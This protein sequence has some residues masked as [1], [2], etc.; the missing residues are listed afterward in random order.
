MTTKSK[1]IFLI[2]FCLIGITCSHV[3]IKSHVT[4]VSA[5]VKADKTVFLQTNSTGAELQSL[6][7]L[8]KSNEY[9]LT[10]QVPSGQY[11]LNKELKIYSNTTILADS[12][13]M[14]IKNHERGS[15]ITND[16]TNDK[17]GY[18][19]AFNITI[20]GGIWDS[21]KTSKGTESFRFIHAT[22]ITIQKA[23][24]CNV[25]EGSKLILFAG[26]KDSKIDGCKLYGYSGKWPK[27]AIQLD[28]VH[29]N[30]LVPSMQ[31]LYLHYDDLACNGILITNNEI[32]NY[33]RAIGSHSSVKGVFHKNITISEN[34]F[35]DLDEA[36]IKAFNYVNLLI[37]NNTITNASLGVLAYTS[38]GD[39]QSQY[40]EP[41]PGT[42]QESLPSTYNIT[43]EGNTIK[44]IHQYKS[45][46]TLIWGDGIRIMGSK[47]RPLNGVFIKKNKISNTKRMGIYT[48]YAPKGYIG[49]NTIT[50]T[51][52]HGIYVD[53]SGGSK[54]EYN[55]LTFPGKVG[56]STGGIGF[57]AS[58]KSKAYKNTVKDAAKNGIFLYNASTN[59]FISA[60]TIFR[61][62][63]NGISV[64]MSS[65]NAMI[66]YNKVTGKSASAL[67]NRGI[68]V[69]KANYATVQN[70]TITDCKSKQE[71]NTN[72]SVGSKLK[73]NKIY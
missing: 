47:E 55:Y 17:G 26:V 46:S 49:N 12:N 29:D 43:I 37:K 27:E 48:S 62:A 33:P 30:V 14:F 39:T 10:V 61:S 23:T 4:K 21:A 57:S 73:E 40:T 41:L 51:D 50:K 9:I 59:C 11:Y 66:S 24:I 65:N 28:I 52:N 25:P 8:N 71:I 69:Y 35:H 6:L 72:N 64:N 42:T 13:A 31:E 18:S 1:N 2:I 16:L 63:D 34:N 68:F 56:T 32:Y 60:N 45:G 54:V 20:S 58:N 53:K 15:M 19:T 67:A 70:N 5:T 22:N 38:I 44:N 3:L 7:D 36:A